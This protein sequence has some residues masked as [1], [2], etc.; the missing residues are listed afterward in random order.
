MPG[1]MEG[2]R[3]LVAGPRNKWSIAWYTAL[4]LHREGAR[5]AFSVLGESEESN[6]AKLLR[7]AEIE[8]PIFQCDARE[9]TQV[10]SLFSHVSEAFDGQLDG[11]VHAIALANTED[12]RGEYTATSKAGF[13]LA[14]ESSVYTLVSL[15]RGARPLMTAA[16]GG[17]IVTFTYIGAERVVPS[18]N[19]M[20]V[21]KAA[22]EA[23]VRYLAA[24]LGQD[25]IR[26]NA[27][28]AGPIKTLA[29]KAISGFDAMRKQVAEISPLRR[30]VEADEVGDATLMLLCPWARGITGEVLYVDGGYHIIGML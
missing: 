8:A 5:L 16:G 11:L 22:L 1:V 28:S 18:Y 10:Q 23:S 15:A 17:S 12:L 14:H 24:D 27:I 29:A 21:A 2:R 6:V 25:N 7:E 4:S 3:V 9:E 26:V 13:A 19:V 30:A 20:G